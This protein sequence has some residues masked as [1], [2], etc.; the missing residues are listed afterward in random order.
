MTMTDAV[1]LRSTFDGVTMTQDRPGPDTYSRD[2]ELYSRVFGEAGTLQV[3]LA[4]CLDDV[5]A[6][7]RLR[8]DI[9]YNEM[10]AQPT[11]SMASIGR[12]FDGYDGI[13]DHLLVIDTA[14]DSGDQVVGTYRLMR[15]EVAEANG[16]FYSAAEFDIDSMLQR[17]GPEDRFMEL[18]RSCVAADY[19]NN[20][21]IQL[22]WRGIAVYLAQYNLNF[23]FGCA[24]FENTNP[25]ELAEPL[26]FLHHF[27]AADE[28]ETVR[29]REELYVDMNMIPADQIDPKKALRTLPPLVKGYLRLGCK[30]GDGAIVDHQFGTTD[31]FIILPLKNVPERMYRHFD[32][33]DRDEDRVR[34]D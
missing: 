22:L 24:S 9:F 3:R 5:I 2:G 13:A 14:R 23:M 32:K 17:A 10:S 18:G 34:K 11:S 26:S 12:D 16:G 28:K 27:C 1:P 21:T 15:Q 25:Q 29:A 7:Q 31:V 8:Y 6:S 30:F 4:N 19:R 20:A 33:A